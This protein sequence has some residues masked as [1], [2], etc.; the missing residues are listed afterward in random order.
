MDQSMLLST[1]QERALP[2]LFP[3]RDTQ[4]GRDSG[5]DA[6][7][8][9]RD[10]W[11]DALAAGEYGR[12]PPKPV[13]VEV[14][15]IKRVKNAFGS[16]AIHTWY[17]LTCA[18]PGGRFSFPFQLVMPEGTVPVPVF[19]QPSF[20]GELPN[21]SCPVSDLM[22]RGFGIASFQYGSVVPDRADALDEGLAGRFGAAARGGD[23]CGAIGY[24]AWAAQRVVD[25]L[26]VH[27][28]VDPARLAIIGHSRLGKTALWAGATDERFSLTVSIQSGCSGAAITRDKAGERVANISRSFPHWFCPDYARYA[29]QEGSMPFEQHQLLASLAPRLLYVSSAQEDGWADP[30]SEF[31]GCV[32]ASPAWDACGVPGFITPDV[33][34]ECGTVLQDGRIGYH[35][36]AGGHALEPEDWRHVMDFW[37]LHMQV[38]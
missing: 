26:L 21:P 35:L 31:L 17:Q 11:L 24:W 28:R 15:E 33:L 8:T 5:G 1:L 18:T 9:R 20:F 4:A 10:L 38:L 37:A 19:V 22:D 12:M 14:R 7:R 2:P 29:D 25:V 16:K 23:G 32:A 27:P 6:G 36:R 30:K 3:E 13:G 34:P